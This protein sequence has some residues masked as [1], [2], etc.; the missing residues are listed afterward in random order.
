MTKIDRLR[1]KKKRLTERR[2]FFFF[3]RSISE[4]ISSHYF[5]KIHRIEREIHELTPKCTGRQMGSPCQLYAIGDTGLCRMH[6]PPPD[7]NQ[8]WDETYPGQ[9]C[10]AFRSKGTPYCHQHI[11]MVEKLK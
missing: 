4:S 11:H 2:D 1:R 9:R 3:F 7:D 6:S 5:F 10:K 8:C